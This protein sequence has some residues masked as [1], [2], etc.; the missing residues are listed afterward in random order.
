ML[1]KLLTA[2]SIPNGGSKTQVLANQVSQIS[3]APIAEPRYEVED[4]R[5]RY[6]RPKMALFKSCYEQRTPW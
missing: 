6:Y 2:Q 3:L 1:Q 4:Q 5:L